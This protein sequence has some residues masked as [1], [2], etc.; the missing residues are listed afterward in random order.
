MVALVGD[1]RGKITVINL[2]ARFYRADSGEILVDESPIRDFG[3]H[4][5][6]RQSGW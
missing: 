1:R 3:I 2:L 5:L 6:R 4:E